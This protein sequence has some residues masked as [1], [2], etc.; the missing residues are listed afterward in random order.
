MPER[1]G[2]KGPPMVPRNEYSEAHDLLN[3]LEDILIRSDLPIERYGML[4]REAEM[5]IV[6]RKDIADIIHILSRLALLI[7]EHNGR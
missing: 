3:K 2:M 5:K 6:G 1:H 4:I 7:D